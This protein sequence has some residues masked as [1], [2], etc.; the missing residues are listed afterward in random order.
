[1]PFRADDRNLAHLHKMLPPD[2]VKIWCA[3][4]NA[5]EVEHGGDHNEC[6][7][8]AWQEMKGDGWT[9][10]A[11]GKGRWSKDKTLKRDDVPCRIVKVDEEQR[12]VYGWASVISE[13]GIAVIDSQGDIIEADE[14]LKATTEFMKDA[15]IAKVMHTGSQMGEVVHSFPLVFE[16]AKGLGIKCDKEGWIV[17]VY[18]KDDEAWQAVK[19]GELP[20]F[21]I[22]GEAVSE[23]A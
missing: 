3:Y 21:S 10:P 18:V 2:G 8:I 7:K 1:M 4:A 16:I 12:M 5:Y 23:A 14:L 22:G 13:R 15:R 9:P 6:V 11:S 20:A 17:G 19:S